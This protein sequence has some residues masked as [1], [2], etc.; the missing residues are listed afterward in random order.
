MIDIAG[1]EQAHHL[2][3]DL[4]GRWA[5]TFF[6]VALLCAGQS[7][8]L[9]GTL[10]GQIVMEGYLHLRITP[11]L[12]RLVTRML[13]L[14]PAVI[15]II[16]TGEDRE[17]RAT[18]QLLVLSQVILSLQLS[19]AVIPLIH[20][21]SSRRNMG[22]F[23][24][25]WWGQIL[26]WATALVIVGLNGKLVLDKA[27]EWVAAAEGVWLGPIPL[28]W[29]VALGLYGLIVAAVGLLIWVTLKPL[30]RPAPPWTPKPTVELDWADA[31][32]PR[33]LTRIGIALE[34]DPGDAEILNRAL[35]LAQPGRTSLV[36]IHVVDTPMT[37]VYGAETD[38]RE[39]GADERYLEAVARVLEQKGY[40]TSSV[41]LYGQSRAGKIVGELKKHPVDLLVVGSHGHGLVRDLLWGQT[42]DKVR[43]GLEIPMLIAR[44]GGHPQ[45]AEEVAQS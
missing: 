27:A 2:L 18:Q 28:A 14:V 13:A 45:T 12:R 6:G 29:L 43:H 37:G 36:L 21:T 5:P 34:H 11:W 3:D 1:I 24:T 7:S 39:S 16:L 31:L 9:T 35:S 40:A 19:F 42:V 41:L 30:V 32:R 26:A 17:G 8:T 15:V 44:P 25:P 22:A 10:A 4:L 38:D 33:A 20:F 23:A